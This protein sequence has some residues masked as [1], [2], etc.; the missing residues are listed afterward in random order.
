MGQRAIC[1]ALVW[2]AGS[3]LAQ[4]SPSKGPPNAAEQT[5]AL[6]A[7]Q[8]YAL[9]YIQRLPDYTCTQVTRRNR[10]PLLASGSR[11]TADTIEEQVSMVDR[12][13]IHMVMKINGNPVTNVQRDQLSGQFSKGEFGS[14]LAIIFDPG[15]ATTFHFDRLATLNGRKMY[16][17]AIGVPQS[18]G[19]LL[20]DSK[21]TVQAP[22]KGF[23]YADY[24]T[25][26]VMRIEMKCIDIPAN[27]E[28]K[29]LELTLDYKP[30][31]VAGQEFIL[32][33]HY[34]LR[35]RNAEVNGSNDA[36]YRGYR[37]FSAD[38]TIKFDDDKQ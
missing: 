16:V 7:I 4:T 20:A 24:Q 12:S 35:F 18:R 5:A 13:E 15:T 33:S 30:T 34:L 38:A 27:S 14:L 22:Y 10:T 32:P 2:M 25:K 23:V 6:D 37:R 3:A 26:A 31:R 28:F 19:Y 9:N 21:R 29:S 1:Y 36:E 17:F 8:E 11:G